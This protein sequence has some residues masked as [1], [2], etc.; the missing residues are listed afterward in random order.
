MLSIHA[1]STCLDSLIG[2]GRDLG[3]DLLENFV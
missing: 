3:V 1:H 2:A